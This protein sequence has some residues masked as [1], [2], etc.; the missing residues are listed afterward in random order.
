M[1]RY[2]VSGIKTPRSGPDELADGILAASRLLVR[3]SADALRAL[4]PE[5]NL[6]EFRALVILSEN[7][8]QRL[9]DIA[10]ALDV[11]STTVT[12]LAD[13]L[14][15]HGFVARVRDSRDRREVYLSIAAA[16]RDLVRAVSSQ[17]RRFVASVLSEF[18]ERDQ[19]VAL[20]VLGRLVAPSG[21]S[22]EE[23]AS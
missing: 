5:M 8:P 16:G 18:P 14:A 22:Y 7:G 15:E 10:A 20:K 2:V 17:R 12:R 6:S 19:E 21:S 13:R 1:M 4:A 3:L 9:V 23:S 11:T